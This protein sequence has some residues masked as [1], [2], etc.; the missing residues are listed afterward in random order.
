MWPT[1]DQF[2]RQTYSRRSAIFQC[3]ESEPNLT[4]DCIPAELLISRLSCCRPSPLSNLRR[5]KQGFH[6][7]LNLPASGS[8]PP[9]SRASL[10]IPCVQNETPRTTKGDGLRV[11]I[12]ADVASRLSLTVQRVFLHRRNW[13]LIKRPPNLLLQHLYQPFHSPPSPTDLIS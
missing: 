13:P 1:N 11:Q 3:Q 7:P 5:S 9:P 4:S 2:D 12:I 10:L 8:T 6:R